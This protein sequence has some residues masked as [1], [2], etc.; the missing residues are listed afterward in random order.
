MLLV[1]CAC[2]ARHHTGRHSCSLCCELASP[3]CWDINKALQD[4]LVS[5]NA[6]KMRSLPFCQTC[7]ERH[8]HQLYPGAVHKKARTVYD[9]YEAIW[10][11]KKWPITHRVPFPVVY[12]LFI[13]CSKVLC[14]GV[15]FIIIPPPNRLLGTE[16]SYPACS[17]AVHFVL[18]SPRGNSHQ[19]EYNAGTPDLGSHFRF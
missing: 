18:Y 15:V 5:V 7:L 1:V 8:L 3:C 14:K 17:E 16:E 10:Q 2:V 11:H 9:L 6:G 13:S 19:E 4:V 12:C